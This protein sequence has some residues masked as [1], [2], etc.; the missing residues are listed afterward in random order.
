[1]AQA[2]K[3]GKRWIVWGA[4]AVALVVVGVAVCLILNN[5][6]SGGKD[7]GRSEIVT[8]RPEKNEGVDN[9]ATEEGVK[10]DSEEE[11]DKRVK[12]YDGED[13]NRASGLTGSVTYA[14][15]TNNRLAVRV[16]IDQYLTSGTCTLEVKQAGVTRLQTEARI[17][18]VASTSTCEGFDVLVDEIKNG[19]FMVVV[20]LES[21]GKK[22]EISRE[23]SI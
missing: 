16:N 9:A 2:R 15:V 23:V 22:G 4:I 19:T 17:V 21:D 20:Y 18:S 14:G 7:E 10:S 3:R 8:A 12:Q 11:D 6:K 5:N 13:P 1:M